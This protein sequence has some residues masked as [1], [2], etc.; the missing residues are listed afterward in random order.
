M[1]DGLLFGNG[2]DRGI[3]GGLKEKIKSLI[4]DETLKYGAEFKKEM[5]SMIENGSDNLK[6]ALCDRISAFAAGIS[7]DTKNE[8]GITTA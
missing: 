5:R 1:L 3:I 8:G 2:K 4:R 7:G 6:K